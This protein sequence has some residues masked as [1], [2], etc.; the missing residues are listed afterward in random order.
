MLRF[1]YW[2]CFDYKIKLFL[3]LPPAEYIQNA[4][5]AALA[6]AG[7]RI[8][9]LGRTRSMLRFYMPTESV[10]AHSLGGRI[11]ATAS[12]DGDRVIISVEFESERFCHYLAA[13]AVSVCFIVLTIWEDKPEYLWI[14]PL[15]FIGIHIIFLLLLPFRVIRLRRF[16]TGIG[17]SKPTLQDDGLPRNRGLRLS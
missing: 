4:Y 3:S 16:F 10:L 15:A 7:D 1:F 6:I 5:K 11:L 12:G 2:L 17:E 8:T 9:V 14:I 13:A